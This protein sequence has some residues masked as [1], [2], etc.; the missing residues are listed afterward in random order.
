[1]LAQALTFDP[2]QQTFVVLD[3]FNILSCKL[4]TWGGFEP[5]S[6]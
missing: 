2:L 1:M 4:F 3:S 5:Q 6:S